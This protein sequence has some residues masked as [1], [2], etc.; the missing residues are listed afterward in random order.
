MRYQEAAARGDQLSATCGH[1]FGQ[2][3]AAPPT[4]FRV[5]AGIV[6]EPLESEH[7][8]KRSFTILLA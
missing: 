4:G 2:K 1:S 7:S 6:P 5:T 3:I 8:S